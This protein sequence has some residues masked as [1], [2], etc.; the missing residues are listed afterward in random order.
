MRLTLRCENLRIAS[1]C[2]P[3][4]IVCGVLAVTGC[5]RQFLGDNDGLKATVPESE[6]TVLDL[7]LAVDTLTGS[8]QPGCFKIPTP[9]TP[10]DI[11]P[12]TKAEIHYVKTAS[13][14]FTKFGMSVNQASN[15]A[16]AK[17]DF[18]ATI[19]S[20]LT[21]AKNSLHFV[22]FA[23]TSVTQSLSK[24]N[25]PR[26]V[27]AAASLPDGT[28]LNDERDFRFHCGNS[29][30]S[31]ITRSN[32]YLGI[33]DIQFSSRGA[34]L[35]AQAAIETKSGAEGT[36][37]ASVKATINS[38]IKQNK[39]EVTFSVRAI[40]TGGYS[41]YLPSAGGTP[42]GEASET[43]GTARFLPNPC[44]MEK[45]ED[46]T[47]A[48]NDMSAYA[49][50]PLSE[51]V[52]GSVSDYALDNYGL[53]IDEWD[54]GAYVTEQSQANGVT[55]E[56][57]EE[58]I[59]N[60]VAT[61]KRIKQRQEVIA[62]V[63]QVKSAPIEFS[64]S[65]VDT[66]SEIYRV[67]YDKVNA[68]LLNCQRI[69]RDP[70]VCRSPTK[71]GL[72][73]NYMTDISASDADVYKEV[74]INDKNQANDYYSECQTDFVVGANGRGGLILNQLALHCGDLSMPNG[75]ARTALDP[76]GD[77]SPTNGNGFSLVSLT[78]PKDDIVV[79]FGMIPSRMKRRKGRPGKKG[80]PEHL[81]QVQY[82]ELYYC[83]RKTVM[84][85]GNN[86]DCKVNV[87]PIYGRTVV[88]DSTNTIITSI[89][90]SSYGMVGL[91]GGVKDSGGI[92]ALGSLGAVCRKYEDPLAILSADTKPPQETKPAQ[93]TT[94]P[95][96][97]TPTTETTTP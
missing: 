83:P 84:S 33:L 87:L 7:G 34:F 53:E 75:L 61:K 56:N 51:V 92:K 73:K 55:P 9:A 5:K 57:Y 50:K 63:Q 3:A 19:E 76:I 42:P 28:P 95:V 52:Q 43:T 37:L 10:G 78:K 38:Q 20:Q 89:C 21:V 74:K 67:D 66:E 97:T 48:L 79:G 77:E 44:T 47:A 32:F 45:F 81:D 41:S 39:S 4:L 86:D 23:A 14:L 71:I 90:A 69:N 65:A 54:I 40:G 88:T 94:P 80:H 24:T 29:F 62:A 82:L 68:E 60:L 36:D 2:K 85:G 15:L 59:K 8:I 96:E 91:Y 25:Y 22:V 1:I 64:I 17:T 72:T 12:T 30:I 6:D 26:F 93:E 70:I 49:R 13:D 31:K 11:Y 35:D 16:V 27:I 18:Q 46:C 58:N